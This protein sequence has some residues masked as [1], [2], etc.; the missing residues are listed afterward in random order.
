MPPSMK[1]TISA[2]AARVWTVQTAAPHVMKRAKF[3]VSAARAAT[4]AT[5]PHWVSA[6][7]AA[8]RP[9]SSARASLARSATSSATRG[10][11]TRTTKTK[12]ALLASSVPRESGRVNQAAVVPTSGSSWTSSGTIRIR[13]RNWRSGST[14]A[15]SL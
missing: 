10:A 8:A 15:T 5:T 1:R 7:S 6:I 3:G 14:M 13:S 2:L 12:A 4:A 11:R 9:S